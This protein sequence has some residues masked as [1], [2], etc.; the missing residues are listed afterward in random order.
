VDDSAV[1]AKEL[2]KKFPA[3]LEFRVTAALGCLRLHDAAGARAQFNGPPIDWSKTPPSWRAVYGAVLIA[4]E[5]TERAREL[6]KTIPLERLAPEEARLINVAP[7]SA[8][9]PEKKTEPLP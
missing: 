1:K 2:A 6:I 3:R 7:E 9:L 4:N 5:Q 8:A